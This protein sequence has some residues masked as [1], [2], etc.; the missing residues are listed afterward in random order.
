MAL[1]NNDMKNELI[2]RKELAR[3]LKI[4]PRTVTTWTKRLN[5]PII[6]GNSRSSLYDWEKVHAHLVKN[7]GVNY[8][9]VKV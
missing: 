4:T 9:E 6:K 3:R 2:N 7:Y 1:K 8:E 5:L